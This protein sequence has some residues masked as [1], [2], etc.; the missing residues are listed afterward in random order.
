MARQISTPPA[1][2]GSPWVD[3]LIDGGRWADADG[4]TVTLTYARMAARSG[5]WGKPWLDWEAEAMD[6]AAARWEAVCNIDFVTVTDPARA[7]LR[8]WLGPQ[9]MVGALAWHQMPTAGGTAPLSGAFADDAKGWSP[10]GLATGGYGFVSL[11]HEL[12]HA[13]GLAHPHG[14]ARDGQTFP[15][16]TGP[17]DLGQD[18]LNQGVW[19]TMGYND[20]WQER[21]STTVD[22]GWQAGPMALDIAAAQAIYGANWHTAPG[23][24]IY[25][26]PLID[27]PGAFWSC[28]WDVG[29][30]DAVS[31]HGA[32]VAA[33]V[34]LRPAPLW[35]AEAAGHVS[36]VGMVAGGL[37]IAA[38]V[39]IE[40]AIGGDGNDRL[41]GNSGD[42][43]LTG[44]PGDDWLDGGEGVDTAQFSGLAADYVWGVDPETGVMC[45]RGADGQD[46]LWLVERLA[47][48]DASVDLADLRPARWAQGGAG[49]DHLRGTADADRLFGQAGSDWLQGM[50]GD[51]WLDGGPGAD[52]MAGGPGHDVYVLDD[53]GDLLREGNAGGFDMVHVS[54]PSY[55]LPR[56][57]EA[58]TRLAAGN[59]SG[60]QGRD[61][62]IG[63][64]G[65]DR[66]AG[67]RGVDSLI[68]GDGADILTGGRG[69]DVLTGGAGADQFVFGPR[70]G[71]DRI[72][73]F[74]PGE[75]RIDLS[76]LFGPVLGWSDA[77]S[78]VPS[79]WLEIGDQ[80]TRLMASTDWDMAAEFVLFLTGA[81]ILAPAD[82]IL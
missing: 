82:V 39:L 37:T 54:L 60:A 2:T 56:G 72:T 8:H 77:P 49:S 63:S 1:P 20:G 76:A 64:S 70:A 22:H 11:V 14:D 26:L 7:D 3:A 71:N 5:P 42:N 50:A 74:T 19:T 75:D 40:Q 31:A 9:R 35:G 30:M 51:D 67:A 6:R 38:G 15:G 23:D 44:G 27:G 53:P 59:L 66:L 68:G 81:L 32:T 46:S 21:P 58:G 33:T 18:A 79:V 24:D 69:Q 4:G 73:D 45:I 16:V 12:G 13:I 41:I 29:G 57:I 52:R 48:A 55:K 62:L 10:S 65:D 17:R 36:S 43:I 61:L 80:E 47:F 25:A 34:D 28:L 78:G